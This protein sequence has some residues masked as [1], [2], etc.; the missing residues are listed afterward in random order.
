MAVGNQTFRGRVDQTTIGV[1]FNKKFEGVTTPGVKQTLIN[2]TIPASKKVNLLQLFVTCRL[3]GKIEIE[4][5]G[6]NIGSGRTGAGKPDFHFSWL[7]YEEVPTGKVLKVFFTA[8][9]WRPSTD[10][11]A[12]MQAREINV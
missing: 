11:E 2:E 4:V 7:P 6:V 9:S 12:W 8:S 10:V 5:D 3:E 1:P